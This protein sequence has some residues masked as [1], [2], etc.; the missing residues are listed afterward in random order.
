MIIDGIEYTIPRHTHNT[1]SCSQCGCATEKGFRNQESVVFMSITSEQ[2]FICAMQTPSEYIGH[3]LL[4][5]NW[6]YPAI[7]ET[8]AFKNC[9]MLLIFFFFINFTHFIITIHVC[10]SWFIFILYLEEIRLS[11]STVEEQNYV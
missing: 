2:K 10:F 3:P 1:V 11:I 6:F 5:S 4:H 8:Y 7:T 9:L